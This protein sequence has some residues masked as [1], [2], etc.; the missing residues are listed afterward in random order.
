MPGAPVR[1]DGAS[2]FVRWP[3]FR[4][5]REERLSKRKEPAADTE[6]DSAF[7]RRA[8]AEARNAEIAQARNEIAL[9]KELAEV[10]SVDD[11]GAALGTIL[12]RLSAR[13]RAMGVRLSHLGPEAE[14]AIEDEAE[15]IIDELSHWDDDVLTSDEEESPS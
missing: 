9:A 8:I 1:R 5:W 4:I 3:D 12:D 14:S 11:Y 13:L 2:V 15:R 6:K 7:K 10:V